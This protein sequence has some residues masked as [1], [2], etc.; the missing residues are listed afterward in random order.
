MSEAGTVIVLGAASGIGRAVA[1]ELARRGHDLLLAGRDPEE[2]AAL[3]ADLRLRHGVQTKR[4]PFDALALETHGAFVEECRL[5]SRDSLAGAV[6]CFGYLGDQSVAEKD[7]LETKRILDTNLLGAAS[8]LGLLANHFEAKRRGFLCA[9]SS[10]AGE[11]GRQSNYVYG[12]AKA[13]LTVFLQ[14]LRNRLFRSGVRVI[15]IKAGFVDTRM[16]FGR[17][18]MFLVASPESAGRAIAR[19][20]GRGREVVYVPGF[21]RAAMLLIRAIPERVFKRLRL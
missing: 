15:T 9:I 20:I 21:W 11:R 16:T 18:G 8:I 14:G 6:V 17:P 10:V 7:P 3:A 1:D 12:A 5:A 2:L 13:G 19:A 4:Q